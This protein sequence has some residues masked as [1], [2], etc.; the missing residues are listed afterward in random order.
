MLGWGHDEAV[1]LALVLP[2]CAKLQSL[3]LFKNKIGDK[4]AAA[5][6]VVLKVTATLTKLR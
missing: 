1:K 2:L 5:I 6:G 4:G 3:T